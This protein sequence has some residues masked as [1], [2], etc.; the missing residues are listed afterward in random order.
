MGRSAQRL[1]PYSFPRCSCLLCLFCHLRDASFPVSKGGR[2]DRSGTNCCHWWTSRRGGLGPC[3][4]SGLLEEPVPSVPQTD[5][6]SWPVGGGAKARWFEAALS[7]GWGRS[8]ESL[9]CKCSHVHRIRVDHEG[10]L[11]RCDPDKP[12]KTG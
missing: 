5:F 10:A 11:V 8:A 2:D 9:P 1:P 6:P 7:W 12:T 3:T 4:A